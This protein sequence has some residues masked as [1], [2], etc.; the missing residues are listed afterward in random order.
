MKIKPTLIFWIRYEMATAYSNLSW[1][2]T[3]NLS[4]TSM[5]H[6]NL[7][8]RGHQWPFYHLKIHKISFSLVSE[9]ALGYSIPGLTQILS[10]LLI[11]YNLPIILRRY[12]IL[13]YERKSVAL[14]ITN[15][16]LYLIFLWYK[17]WVFP[18]SLPTYLFFSFWS[19]CKS[20]KVFVAHAL[21]F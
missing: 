4:L 15:K 21:T 19:G 2:L 18:S 8:V 10:I 5:K 7:S 17:V 3:E 6:K 16:M 1:N 9:S 20:K 13:L 12:E 11:L 14:I